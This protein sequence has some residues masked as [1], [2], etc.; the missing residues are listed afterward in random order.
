M[1]KSYNVSKL[2]RHAQIKKNQNKISNV[3]KVNSKTVKNT[4]KGGIDKFV[5]HRALP[6]R[7]CRDG[8][9]KHLRSGKVIQQKIKKHEEYTGI[10]GWT[11]VSEG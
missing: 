4:F 3:T 1:Q 10:G 8:K 6:D 5:R 9:N 7:V 2:K 11:S